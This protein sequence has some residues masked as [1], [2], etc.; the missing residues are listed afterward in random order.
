MVDEPSASSSSQTPAPARASPKRPHARNVVVSSSSLSFSRFAIR[1]G[2]PFSLTFCI[3]KR[4]DRVFPCASCI[5]R[6]C[7]NLC[8][9]GTLEKG[10]RGF[11]KRLEQSLPSSASRVPG[12]DVSA[13]SSQVA[14]FVERDAAMIKRIQELES[15]LTRYEHLLVAGG[16][17]LNDP[18]LF[19]RAGV[20]IP[21]NPVHSLRNKSTPSKRA[22]RSTPDDATSDDD[23]ERARLQSSSTRLSSSAIPSI[24]D[25]DS[26]HGEIADVDLGFGTLTIDED[27][28]SRY[29]GPSG[30][31][32]YLD[33]EVI[34]HHSVWSKVCFLTFSPQLWNTS[35]N[36]MPSRSDSHEALPNV[37]LW[38]RVSAQIY[39]LTRVR[40]ELRCLLP[41][42]APLFSPKLLGS[43]QIRYVLLLRTFRD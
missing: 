19:P 38:Q 27:N 9:T 16:G 32:A 20:P 24:A 31:S 41:R 34:P 30:A 28:R 17:K 5:R 42:P 37:G 4:C 13:D 8:P 33:T 7:A 14:M 3:N 40:S 6:G 23:T 10:K 35:A 29:I 36:R 22:R 26:T 43:V 21:G 12:E 25:D 11:L 2:F 39:W 18:L 15:A 1:L